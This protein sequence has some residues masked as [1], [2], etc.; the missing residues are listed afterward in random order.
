[1]MRL[2]TAATSLAMIILLAGCSGSPPPASTSFPGMGTTVTVQVP[3]RQR[4]SLGACANT[5]WTTVD[6]L[7][8]L[9]S[10]YEPQSEISAINHVAGAVRLP[11]SLDTRRLLDRALALSLQTDGAFDITAAPL[12]YLW[13]FSGGPVPEEPLVPELLEAALRGVGPQHVQLEGQFVQT[14]SSHTRLDLGAIARGYAVDLSVLALR[15]AGVH[16]VMVAIGDHARCLGSASPRH[17]WTRD[18]ED[19]FRPGQQLGRLRIGGGRA[20]SVSALRSHF[21]TIAGKDYGHII[22]PRSGRPAEGTALA[23]VT[24]PT[25]TEA[26]ALATALVVVG[27]EGAPRLLGRFPRCEALIVPDAEPAVL[28]TTPGFAAA[29]EP[30]AASAQIGALEREPAGAPGAESPEEPDAL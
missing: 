11:V 25:A 24:G 26:D 3:S 1:M 10:I 28:W 23:V 15:H 4:D 29:F 17:E 6:R 18:I 5:T 22:D 19:P 12:S 21:V 30:A 13:G 8:K 7:N 27:I 9:L 20:V 14:L 16:D 2:H